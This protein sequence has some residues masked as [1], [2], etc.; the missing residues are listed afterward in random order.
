MS[1]KKNLYNEFL[2][3]SRSIKDEFINK[4]TQ[5]VIELLENENKSES[6]KLLKYSLREIH[7][8]ENFKKVIQILKSSKFYKKYKCFKTKQVK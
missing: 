4:R 1:K 8:A 5:A 3:Q 6:I 7:D 2:K